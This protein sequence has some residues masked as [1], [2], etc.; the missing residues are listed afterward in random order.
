[1]AVERCSKC[2][3]DD[4][5]SPSVTV[6]AIATRNRNEDLELLMIKSLLMMIL[7]RS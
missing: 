7:L 2:G 1:M 5:Q 6:D 3:R 4:Y